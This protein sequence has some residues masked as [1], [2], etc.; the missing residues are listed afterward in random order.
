MNFINQQMG[1]IY[2]TKIVE[3]KQLKVTDESI[4]CK[5]SICGDY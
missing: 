3:Y 2:V 1:I 4:E 5:T